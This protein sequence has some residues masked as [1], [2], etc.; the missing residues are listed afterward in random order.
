VRDEVKMVGSLSS[1]EYPVVVKQLRQVYSTGKVAVADLSFKVPV[2][3]VFGLL[4][5]NGA[6]K[7]TTFKILS[8]EIKPS[9]GECWVSGYSLTTQLAEAR[10]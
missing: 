7:S 10:K 1:N 8:G 6:G 2:G 4:G 9:S 3:E 5:V